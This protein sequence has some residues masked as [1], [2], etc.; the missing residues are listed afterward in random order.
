MHRNLIPTFVS[1]SHLSYVESIPTRYSQPWV[2]CFSSYQDHATGLPTI[3]SIVAHV[4]FVTTYIYIYIYIYIYVYI[5]IFNHSSITHIKLMPNSWFTH[6]TL[7]QSCIIIPGNPSYNNLYKHKLYIQAQR[8]T[9][10]LCILAQLF[11]QARE[12]RSSEKDSRLGELP[13]P[14]GELDTHNSGLCALSLR[15]DSPRLSE[16]LARS[17]L[18]WSPERPLT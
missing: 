11:A 9:N 14:R 18:S 12:S 10:S 3:M 1:N 8:Q 4:K 15:R 6:I 16:T 17:K 7:S 13:S 2:K 5:Y